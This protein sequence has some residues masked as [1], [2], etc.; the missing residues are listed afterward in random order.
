M[1]SVVLGSHY[2][3][4]W[5]HNF[6][7][8]KSS[9]IKYID[10]I[11]RF[12]LYLLHQGFEGE[13]DFDKFHADRNHPGRFL[14]MKTHVIDNFTQYLRETERVS[15]SLL[16]A[17]VTGLKNFFGYLYD[18]DLIQNNPMLNYPTPKYER[19][20]QNSA[21]SK[22]ECIAL[23]HAA[24]KREPFYRQ[25]YVM[26]W[27]MLIT[28]LR[29]S[30]VRFLRRFQV[31]LQTRI[32]KITQGQKT[33]WGI[34]AITE[35]LAEEINRYVNHPNYL[36]HERHGEEFLFNH[37]GV[38]YSYTRFANML[39]NISKDAGLLRNVS[40]HDLRRSAAYLMQAGG[41]NIIDIQHQLRHKHLGTTLSYVPPIHNLSEILEE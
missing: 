1:D 17:T 36:K 31:N 14:P 4:S 13:L 32:V 15:D 28:G 41:F 18:M 34:V 26:I 40:P 25:A 11:K 9:K 37:N 22:D 33:D 12:E 38:R 24:V 19:R 29:I 39:K 6:K 16:S 5:S 2:Y 21:L 3:Y 8:S 20:I 10:A 23:L 30:E 7:L 27:F 35:A